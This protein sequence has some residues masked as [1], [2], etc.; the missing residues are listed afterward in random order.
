MCSSTCSGSGTFGGGPPA[1]GRLLPEPLGIRAV[2]GRLV[3]DDA[4]EFTRDNDDV[5]V[6]NPGR[7]G[8]G[9]GPTPVYDRLG[10]GE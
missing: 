8:K 10:A 3:E 6:G 2:P 7:G 1:P 4:G 9:P 5:L